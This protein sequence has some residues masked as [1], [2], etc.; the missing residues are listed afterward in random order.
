MLTV[1]S[2]VRYISGSRVH[3]YGGGAFTVV[4]D[5]DEVL[6]SNVKDGRIWRVSKDSTEP[7]PLTAG[8]CEALYYIG[9]ILDQPSRRSATL[10]WS[11]P[12]NTD[13]NQAETTKLTQPFLYLPSSR[14]LDSALCRF[15]IPPTLLHYSSLPPLHSRRTRRT[16]PPLNGEELPRP[17]RRSNRI[18]HLPSSYHRLLLLLFLESHLQQDLLDR[19]G[20]SKHALGVGEAVRR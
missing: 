13:E 1:F 14:I 7:V 5:T 10:W 18:H 17:H 8:K 19:M 15:P 20:S 3:E 9:Y 2:L 6:F 12:A 11:C 4:P 16:L